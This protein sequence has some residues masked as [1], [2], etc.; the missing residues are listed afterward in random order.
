MVPGGVRV[1][2][3]VLEL[4]RGSLGD[5]VTITAPGWNQSNPP[6]TEYLVYADASTDGELHTGACSRNRQLGDGSADHDLAWLRAYPTADGTAF[7]SGRV[8]PSNGMPSDLPITITATANGAQRSA[9]VADDAY[10]IHGLVAGTYTLR[11]VVPAGYAAGKAQTVT[12]EPKGCAEVYWRLTGDAHVRGRVLTS[13]GEP[14]KTTV[15]LL[16]PDDSRNGF[17]IAQQADTDAEGRYD[18]QNAS[19]GQ[20]WVAL[21]PYGPNK[22]DPQIITVYPAAHALANA[23]LLA[24]RPGATLDGIDFVLPSP[25]MPATVHVVVQGR[26][27]SVLA[28]ARLDAIDPASPT[29]ANTATT[30]SAGRA[31]LALY[32]DRQYVLVANMPSDASA[33]SLPLIFT[34]R[35]GLALGPLVLTT[36]FSACRKQQ[37]ELVSNLPHQTAFTGFTQT[38]IVAAE[39]RS[40]QT[41]V[42]DPQGCRRLAGSLFAFPHRASAAHRWSVPRCRGCGKPSAR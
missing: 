25:L 39:R 35:D 42:L 40:Q 2:F 32:A 11:A 12:L 19:L 16:R 41:G 9:S 34:A 8:I 22:L 6:G 27:G 33:C 15:Y 3:Q 20:Y 36:T 38:A 14:A 7:I 23:P 5:Q 24:L 37:T 4:F 30:D 13:A 29:W 10:E 17:T 31:D 21:D 1:V 28:G 26:E 18:I